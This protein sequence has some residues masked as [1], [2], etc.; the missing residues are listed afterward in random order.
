MT[1]IGEQFQYIMRD[2]TV[3]LNFGVDLINGAKAE[4][5]DLWTPAFQRKVEGLIE[6]G[7]ELEVA[8]A[9]EVLPEGLM[10]LNANM[11]RAYAQYTPAADSNGSAFPPAT[12]RITPSRG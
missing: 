8:Y 1:G 11:F 5:L 9:D 3:H 10:G 12:E 4:N 6:R 7:V 2:E